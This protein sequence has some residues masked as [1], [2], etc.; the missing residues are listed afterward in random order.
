M[1]AEMVLDRDTLS[2]T[3]A[4]ITPTE[5]EEEM[6]FKCCHKFTLVMS[7]KVMCVPSCVKMVL[8]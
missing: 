2:I 6:T 3:G 4:A 1:P 7:H 8:L 5:R